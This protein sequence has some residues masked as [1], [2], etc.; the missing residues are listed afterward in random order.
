MKKTVPL[1]ILA[2]ALTVQSQT[3]IYTYDSAG[4]RISRTIGSAKSRASFPLDS[5][6]IGH[7][8]EIGFFDIR[9]HPTK[10]SDII[11]IDIPLHNESDEA[12][13]RLYSLLGYEL[14]SVKITE[15][16]SKIDLTHLS[17]GTYVLSVIINGDITSTKII[18]Q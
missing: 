4:N 6:D 2:S 12:E 7:P 18:K 14:M 3:V 8:S 5:L 9:V 15:P 1:I 11:N 16:Y 17:A 10:T 13:I